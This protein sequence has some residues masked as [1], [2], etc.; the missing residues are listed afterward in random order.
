MKPNCFKTLAGLLVFASYLCM[1][2]CSDDKDDNGAYDGWVQAKNI[3][4]S[5]CFWGERG[6]YRAVASVE[7]PH[8]MLRIDRSADTLHC[9]LYDYEMCCSATSAKVFYIVADG[10]IDIRVDQNLGDIA[11]TCL[12]QFNLSFD[13]VG[14]GSGEYQL[15]RRQESGGAVLW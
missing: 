7:S 4:Q 8:A 10:R 15:A 1:A 6:G 3:R 14:V 11:A 5:E 13:V 12:C 2:A 9:T